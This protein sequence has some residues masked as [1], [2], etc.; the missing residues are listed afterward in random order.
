MR[1]QIAVTEGAGEVAVA[2]DVALAAGWTL[3][4]EQ[5]G[6]EVARIRDTPAS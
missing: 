4:E 3:A 5:F 2:D 6:G 1:G